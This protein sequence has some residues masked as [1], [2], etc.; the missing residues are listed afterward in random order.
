MYLMGH[1][2]SV[3]VTNFL[4]EKISGKRSNKLILGIGSMLPD[5]IDKPIGSFFFDTG[6]WLGHSLLFLTSMIVIL[7]IIEKYSQ[8]ESIY[9][10]K[11]NK[12]NIITFYI[13][14]LA[15][16]IG[17]WGISWKVVLWPILGPFPVGIKVSFLF[18]IENRAI[19]LFELLG[20]FGIVL[21]GLQE[22]W[23]KKDWL[24]YVFLW[25]I[26]LS[27]YLLLYIMIVL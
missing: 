21:V 20:T 27:T 11:Y 6:R 2:G 26:Y 1:L 24:Q 5:I 17:D 15:H 18:G 25:T 22:K 8:I 14:T 19:L 4:Y 16:L 7:L 3:L 13:A 12:K 23:S 10:I 9:W